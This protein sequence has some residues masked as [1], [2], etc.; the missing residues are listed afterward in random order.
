MTRL[1]LPLVLLFS[2][3]ANATPIYGCPVIEPDALVDTGLSSIRAPLEVTYYGGGEDGGTCS[4]LLALRV[5]TLPSRSL[6][7]S[8]RELAEELVPVAKAYGA[9]TCEIAVW[10][11]DDTDPEADDF[12]ED[13]CRRAEFRYDGSTWWAVGDEQPCWEE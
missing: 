9:K 3:L 11:T 12:A 5:S 10:V 2:A 1:L 7:P 4:A 13:A 6:V 8:P